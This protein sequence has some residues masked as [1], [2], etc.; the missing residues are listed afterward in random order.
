MTTEKKIYRGFLRMGSNGEEENI[1]FLLEGDPPELHTSIHD[2]PL[3]KIIADDMEAHGRHLTVRYFTS[4]KELTEDELMVDFAKKVSGPGD[5]LYG[6][7]YSEITGY[8]YTNDEIEVGGHN[9]HAELWS[10]VGRFCHLEIEYSTEPVPSTRENFKHDRGCRCPEHYLGQ[11]GPVYRHQEGHIGVTGREWPK[12]EH[13]GLSLDGKHTVEICL[14]IVRKERIY[15]LGT[16]E[17]TSH[18]LSETT[19]AIQGMLKWA[20]EHQIHKEQDKKEKS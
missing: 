17:K 19:Q 14:D 12:C 15:L 7:A 13:C 9:L 16:L 3:S 1:L 6:T 18:L 2:D 20:K 10:Q 4:E 5:A 8:L 11:K